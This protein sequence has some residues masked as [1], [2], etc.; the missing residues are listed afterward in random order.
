MNPSLPSLLA[1]FLTT[2]DRRTAVLYAL[3]NDGCAD[4][5]CASM[6]PTEI[7][8]IEGSN[9]NGLV[10]CPR[11]CNKCGGP[12][13]GTSGAESG[14]TNKE[15][16][17]NGVLNN[18]HPC[19]GTNG[20]PCIIDGTNVVS[21]CIAY[22]QQYLGVHHTDGV[23][24]PLSLRSTYNTARWVAPHPDESLMDCS[25]LHSICLW[26]SCF[27]VSFSELQPLFA[28][29]SLTPFAQLVPN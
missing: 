18:Q 20:A 14:L 25:R 16:C 1:C 21:Q 5:L 15:C 24:P 27:L 13:C 26:R 3:T 9:D 4:S 29:Q 10:C 8:G 19:S 12:N 22:G 23:Y 11:E 6:L 28:I 7:P 17:V 2:H